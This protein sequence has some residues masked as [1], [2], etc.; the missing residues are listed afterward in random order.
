MED[1]TAQPRLPKGPDWIP[2]EP[3]P[4]RSTP[5][6][7]G[8]RFIPINGLRAVSVLRL[9]PSSHSS[10]S[11][12]WSFLEY[13]YEYTSRNTTFPHCTWPFCI[14]A[15]V[16]ECRRAG[17]PWRGGRRSGV[18][19]RTWRPRH[20]G[21]EL[22]RLWCREPSRVRH[23]L[24]SSHLC[25]SGWWDNPTPLDFTNRQRTIPYGSGA[26]RTRWGHSSDY[27]GVPQCRG[28]H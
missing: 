8:G 26:N 2:P 17:L 23:R 20:R 1:G 27:E 14:R 10:S 16:R 25:F 9:C 13:G 12:S 15:H 24:R 22:E 18:R 3:N 6:S 7:S 4:V 5:G 21:D 28:S 11:I 19:R